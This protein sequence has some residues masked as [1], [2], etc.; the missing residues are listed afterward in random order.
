MNRVFNVVSYFDLIPVEQAKNYALVT[1]PMMPRGS[2]SDSFSAP[3]C[4]PTTEQKRVVS[5]CQ[6]SAMLCFSRVLRTQTRHYIAPKRPNTNTLHSAVC[7]PPGN[8]SP[9]AAKRSHQHYPW[10]NGCSDLM[11]RSGQPPHGFRQGS[12]RF[13]PPLT[14]GPHLIY[15]SCPPPVFSPS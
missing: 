4:L 15:K 8:N 7:T 1:A 11:R 10:Q 9:Q 14:T 5:V 6:P 2:C 13:I 3:V 12:V